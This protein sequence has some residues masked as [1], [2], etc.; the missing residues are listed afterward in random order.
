MNRMYHSSLV[1]A[2]HKNVYQTSVN[3][4][5]CDLPSSS[6]CVCVFV[7]F[8]SIFSLDIFCCCSYVESLCTLCLI[9]VFAHFPFCLSCFSTFLKQS[10]LA[11][12]YLVSC[13]LFF[14]VF[15]TIAVF[16]WRSRFF[17]CTNFIPFVISVSNGLKPR[18]RHAGMMCH[19]VVFGVI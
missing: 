15:I 12:Q 17:L 4:I 16:V 7:C 2:L 6:L 9:S 18:T 19:R 13:S 5:F 14:F 10:K 1:H 3:I 11:E 8:D